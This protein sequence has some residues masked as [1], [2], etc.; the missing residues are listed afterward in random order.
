MWINTDYDDQQND[1][2]KIL[3]TPSFILLIQNR[4]GSAT[5]YG[6]RIYAV[7]HNDR[8]G[9]TQD[10]VSMEY[11]YDIPIDN[12]WQ[13]IVLVGT[14]DSNSHLYLNG[15][16][17]HPSETNLDTPSLEYN[18][19]ELGDF[20]GKLDDVRI[21]DRAL[22][23]SEVSLLR[24]SEAPQFQIVQGSF[25][26]QEAKSDAEARGGRL[27]VLNTQE[28]IDAANEYL[29]RIGGWPHTWI[30]LTD[31]VENN[32]WVWLDNS[33]LYVSNWGGNEPNNSWE[34]Y[35]GIWDSENT[36]P[37]WAD[38]S[39]T[40]ISGAYLL[41]LLPPDTDGD[42]LPDSIETN[43]GVFVSLTDTG[44]DPNNADSLHTPIEM[45]TA[46]TESRTLGQ[47]DVIGS[48]SDYNL[49]GAEGVFDMR[50]SQPGISMN[51][52]KASMN[53]TIQ[54][55]NNLE[56]WNNEETIRRDYTMP[57]DK[58]F[59]RVSVGPEIEPEP[60]PLP[61]IATDTYGDKL[62]YDESNNLYVNDE[63]T[64]LIIDGVNLRT[65][66][67]A[68]WNFYAIESTGSRY[69]CIL[70]SSTQIIDYTFDS[71]GNYI[72]SSVV[73]NLSYYESLLGQSLN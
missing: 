66:T 45:T 61:A 47:Q 48:P 50:V 5:G 70:K 44:T 49:M 65:D 19:T 13:H 35:A 54:S 29:L 36:P 22:T 16:K 68:G 56:E 8:E 25:N 53:F 52:D 18:F 14:E 11:F 51:G 31:E 67:Y 59:M 15:V 63:D 30:G 20:N 34:N 3:T 64:P 73:V 71:D 7:I 12:S 46:I 21:Y 32:S 42:G 4:S 40:H 24:Y 62:V 1:R 10:P 69:I 38:Y 2:S 17:Y 33:N 6:K 39:S 26:W 57:S 55:S 23:A 72:S 43:T 37:K 41:E 58:N 28:K 9:N 60:E 27:A